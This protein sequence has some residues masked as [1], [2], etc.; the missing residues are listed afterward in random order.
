MPLDS[1]VFP[2]EV[3]VAFFIFSLLTDNWE[4]MSGTYMGKSW[5]SI[6]YI[7]S[8]YEIDD[9]KTV[10]RFMKMYEIELVNYRAQESEKRRKA[11]ERK[12]KSSGGGKNYTHNVKG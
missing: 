5:D 9:P 2:E 10:F 4:G 1:S 12:S 8:L 6:E 7:M 3:Q 11:E